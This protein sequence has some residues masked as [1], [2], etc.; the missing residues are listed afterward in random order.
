MQERGHAVASSYTYLL[1]IS[2]P[3]AMSVTTSRTQG[4][5]VIGRRSYRA[6]SGLFTVHPAVLEGQILLCLQ[7]HTYG[8]VEVV[9]QHQGLET[10]LA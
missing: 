3:V 8:L 6:I 4:G 9:G 2:F 5:G 10:I 1:S 7:S